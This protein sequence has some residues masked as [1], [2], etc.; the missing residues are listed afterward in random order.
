MS[1]TYRSTAFVHWCPKWWFPSHTF[2]GTVYNP[3][4]AHPPPT[5]PPTLFKCCGHRYVKRSVVGVAYPL[6]GELLLIGRSSADC[7]SSVRILRS[8]PQ[9]VCVTGACGSVSLEAVYLLSV[10]ERGRRDSHPDVLAWK[11]RRV[12]QK[13]SHQTGINGKIFVVERYCLDRP[14]NSDLKDDI[15]FPLKLVSV[16]LTDNSS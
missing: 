13:M 6:S 10:K 2:A 12:C 9:G 5:P 3:G 8:H 1:Q 14:H 7:V 16:S 11:G 4:D 15:T